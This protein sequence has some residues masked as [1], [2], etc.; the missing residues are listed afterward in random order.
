MY[1]NTQGAKDRFS[2]HVSVKQNILLVNSLYNRKTFYSSTH[3]AP[4]I[5]PI[6]T[7]TLGKQY[8]LSLLKKSTN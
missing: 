4:V 5:S 6:I 1:G 3:T 7:L 8:Y 2:R